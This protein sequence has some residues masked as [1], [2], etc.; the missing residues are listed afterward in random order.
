MLISVVNVWEV[1]IKG[2]LGKLELPDDMEARIRRA[3]TVSGFGILPVELRH[4]LAVRLLP[5]HHK[6]PFDRILVAQAQVDGL[7]LVTTDRWLGAYEV[8]NVW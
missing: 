6:D 5:L 8:D 1:G 7:S 3:C 2:P 4:A